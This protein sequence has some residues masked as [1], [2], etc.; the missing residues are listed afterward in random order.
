MAGKTILE[1]NVRLALR[2]QEVTVTIKSIPGIT[3]NVGD[4]CITDIT[5]DITGICTPCVTIGITGT[6][7]IRTYPE[8][9]LSAHSSVAKQFKILTYYVYAPLFHCFAPCSEP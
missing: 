3:T 6:E 8:N 1:G 9:N 2:I 4:I 7:T 5:T